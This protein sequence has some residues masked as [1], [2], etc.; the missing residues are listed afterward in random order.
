MAERDLRLIAS[1]GRRLDQGDLATRRNERKEAWRDL[2]NQLI[3]K[4]LEVKQKGQEIQHN[5]AL[6]RELAQETLE[7]ENVG[8]VKV[9]ELY[10]VVDSTVS[11]LPRAERAGA[12]KSIR[13][14]IVR[15]EKYKQQI[16]NQIEKLD[17]ARVKLIKEAEKL[18]REIYLVKKELGQ[19]DEARGEKQSPFVDPR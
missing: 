3:A 18:Q 14:A 17:S 11:H 12:K 10:G 4:N 8:V 1:N 5:E 16:K 6:L 13:Q 9:Y 15:V 19:L 7:V 2:T